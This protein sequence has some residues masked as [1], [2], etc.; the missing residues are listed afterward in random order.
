M[1]DWITRSGGQRRA[2]RVEF[3]TPD[4]AR[5]ALESTVITPL[6]QFGILD[7]TGS[8]AERFLQGQTSAQ[9]S[10]ANG[11]FAPLT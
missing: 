1:T 3:D 11:K 5:L 6:A 4:Q 9:V 7:I 2:T 10:L 8:D